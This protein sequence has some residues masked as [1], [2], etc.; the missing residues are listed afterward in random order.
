MMSGS[1]GGS[2][3]AAT[4]LGPVVAQAEGSSRVESNAAAE[5]VP[6]SGLAQGQKDP[7]DTAV[8]ED[9]EPSAAAFAQA[10]AQRPMVCGSYAPERP[11]PIYLRGIVERGFG[12]GGKEL[13]C[14]TG[15]S[16]LSMLSWK[17]QRY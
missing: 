2:S 9:K 8:E 7:L 1:G 13:G 14:P 5:Q 10:R 6:S 4:G 17:G 12:R 15:E 3:A 11:Y 16:C